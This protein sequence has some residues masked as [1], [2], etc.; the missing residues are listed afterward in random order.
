MDIQFCD[1]CSESVPVSDFKEGKAT[2]HKGRLICGQCNSAMGGAAEG[3]TILT[4]PPV[5]TATG[6]RPA[7]AAPRSQP[8]ARSQAPLPRSSAPPVSAVPPLPA[9]LALDHP[10]E[11]TRAWPG[12]VGLMA[13]TAALV[14]VGVGGVLVLDRLDGIQGD[15]DSLRNE[16]Q[17]AKATLRAE[18]RAM[19]DPLRAEISASADRAERT[20]SA[21]AEAQ[22]QR[23]AQL[24]QQLA[25][26]TARESEL[27]AGIDSVRTLV[28]D[29]KRSLDDDR[30]GDAALVARLDKVVDFHGNRLIELEERIREAGALVAAG[31]VPPGAA[32]TPG[33]APAGPTWEPLVAELTS[34]DAAVRLQAAYDLGETGDQAVV[35]HLIPMLSDADVFV[36]MVT[37]QALDTLK[38]RLAV[39]A[40]VDRLEDETITVREAALIALRNITGQRFGYEPDA[41][42]ADRKRKVD[43]WRSWW[44]REGDDFLAGGTG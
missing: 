10:T 30:R 16:N 43:Q 24:E 12:I 19:L 39:P 25:A 31:V 26:A 35:P 44:R 9:S 38:A 28:A 14:A 18:Q 21:A 23:I 42:Q 13:G 6:I 29:T 3:A 5:R 33:A 40:L 2:L 8:A 37:A 15:A 27:R 1:L 32:G 41:R 20:A 34:E 22:S 11:P 4:A 17:R 7:P 36:R